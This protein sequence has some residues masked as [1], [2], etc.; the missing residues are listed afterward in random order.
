MFVGSFLFPSSRPLYEVASGSTHKPLLKP[1]TKPFQS[2]QKSL[3]APALHLPDLTCPFSIYV[4][5]KEGF[6]LRVLGTRLALLLHLW[7][8]CQKKQTKTKTNKQTNKQK[9]KKPK[10]Q[11]TKQNKKP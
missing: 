3:K 1:I 4:T 5:E 11:K 9:P 7:H 6:D 8:I 2:L 10:N